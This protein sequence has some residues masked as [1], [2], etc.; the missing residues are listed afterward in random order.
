MTI[1]LLTALALAVI[2]GF[3]YSYYQ[4]LRKLR[5]HDRETVRLMELDLERLQ[6]TGASPDAIAAFRERIR[7]FRAKHKVR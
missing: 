3:W 5:A 1:L 2:A 4:S 7:E 6:T